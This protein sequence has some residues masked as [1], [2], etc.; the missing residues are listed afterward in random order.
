[1]KIILST[2]YIINV[3]DFILNVVFASDNNY[4]PYLSVCMI[5]L[6]DNNSKDFDKINI[7]ILDDNISND[8][9]NKLESIVENYNA[10]INFINVN[11]IEKVEGIPPIIRDNVSSFTTYSRLFI[12][13]LLPKSIDKVLYLDCDSLICGSFKELWDLDIKNY[14]CATV[15]D[16]YTTGSKFI[17][18]LFNLNQDGDYYNAG[19]LLINLEYWRKNNIES[20]FLNFLVENKSKL[21]WH[22]QDVINAV[23]KDTILPVDLKYNLM[24]CLHE[25][26]FDSV[27]KWQ[28]LW[29]FYDKDVVKNAQK[30]P[31]F[32]HFACIPFLRPWINSN[33]KYYELYKK[34]ASLSPFYNVIFKNND[35]SNYELFRYKIYNSFLMGLILSILPMNFCIKMKYNRQSKEYKKIMESRN[36]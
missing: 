28:A 29:K 23:L 1:M 5:S 36:N 7:F 27:R 18:E 8:N 30:N 17:K 20:K 9:K 15:Y 16:Q 4:V 35:F 10:N 6:L 25:L 13:S 31:V 12:P 3:G 33:S 2:F 14:S 11:V 19:F 21:L 24:S 22:D 26:S 32:L 34:Y